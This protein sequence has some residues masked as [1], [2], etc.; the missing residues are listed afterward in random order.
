MADNWFE[1][2]F[3]SKDYL[4]LYKHRNE[5]DARKIVSL[6]T[7][8]VKLPKGSKVLD[9]AC[10]NGRHSILFAGKGFNVLGIDLSSFLIGQAKQKLKTDYRK[11]K[12][13]LRF[14]LGDMRN[15]RHAKEFDLVV[16]LFSSFG[17][18]EKDSENKRV[19]KS[20]SRSLKNGGYFFFDFLNARYLK[21]NI[22]PFDVT[23]RNR[24]II[25][26]V[27]EITGGLIK[28]NILIFKDNTRPGEAVLNHFCEKI[29]LYLPVDFKKMFKTSGLNIIRV[30]GDYKGNTF[31][32]NE[33]P[34]LIILA[35][36]K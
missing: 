5:A 19:I 32:S 2:W 13:N 36:K 3:N 11:Y 21:K 17:Y 10:G 31:N 18:F 23:K 9:L 28:K 24:N 34:R 22:V 30:F 27:R 12:K 16:N 1:K 29:K 20:I 33:S 8:T 26:Q 35:Q 15:I 14:E 6:I 4:E 7:R 25:V